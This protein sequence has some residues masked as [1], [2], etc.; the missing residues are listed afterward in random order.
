VV[1]GGSLAGL[2]AARVLANHFERV[3]IL[4]RD[5]YPAAPGPRRGVPQARHL[6]ALLARGRQVL[7]AFFPKLGD[8]LLDQ[9]AT[10]V[11]AARDVAWLTPAG[12]G[13]RFECGIPLVACSRDLIDWA[14]RRRVAA[15][16]NVGFRE[17]VDV[18][19][20]VAT[21]D[22]RAIAGVELRP[23]GDAGLTERLGAD[24]VVDASGRSSRAPHWLAALGY[25][26]PEETYVNAF[27]GYA[28]R[29][30]RRPPGYESSWS[31]MYIQSAPPGRPRAGLIF[32]IEDGRWMVTLGGGGKDYPPTDEDG[33]RD[34]AGSLP[35]ADFADALARAEPLGPIV[36]YRNTEN[37][38]RHYERLPLRPERFVVTGDAACAF[39]PVYGQGM[40]TAALGAEALDRC[41]RAC[42]P[43]DDL[44]GLAARFQCALAHEN[45]VP[46]ALATGED[47]RYRITEGRPASRTTRLLHRYLD[48]V[49]R[50]SLDDVSVRT[51]V[52]QVFH[53][54]RPPAA[55]LGPRIAG[56]VLWRSLCRGAG[57]A[58]RKRPAA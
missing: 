56:R 57:A 36:G 24:L 48:G 16:P 15:L 31:A 43:A 46:W 5:R 50:L 14:V 17:E 44:T 18:T 8:E 30:Y 2:L 1:I 42:R 29:V 32:P 19:G 58:G 9:G 3:T 11:D 54:L 33:F 45:A 51:T 20:L 4:E 53:M 49:I 38:R 25:P 47:Y 55:F 52:L 22:G 37:R 26:E 7:E 41:L 35:A 23:R 13:P 6:H 10:L 12:W 21:P 39:N 28:S 27:L 40:T 34:F